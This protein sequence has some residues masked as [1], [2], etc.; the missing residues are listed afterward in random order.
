MRRTNVHS[1]GTLAA[2][3]GIIPRLD[4]ISS[5]STAFPS[6]KALA[7]RWLQEC[8]TSHRACNVDHDRKG[9]N[10]NRL[11]DVGRIRDEMIQLT[12]TTPTEPITYVTLSHRWGQVDVPLLTKHTEASFKSGIAICDLPKT[13]QHAVTVVRELGHRYLWIDSLCIRQDRDDLSDWLHEASLM[14]KVYGHGHFNISATGAIDG[15]EG[16]F[17]ERDHTARGFERV[18]LKVE[19]L[20]GGPIPCIAFYF[21]FWT[22]NVERAPLN[23]RGWVLQERIL[24]KRV[25]HF[26]KTQLFWECR[27]LQAAETFPSG[28]SYDGSRPVGIKCLEPDV[29]GPLNKTANESHR[30]PRFWAY[31]LWTGIA[32]TYSRCSLTKSGDKFLAIMGLAKHMN[33]LIKDMYVAG[34]WRKYLAS[35]L[36]WSVSRHGGT[37]PSTPDIY[38]A[39]T[40]SW[41]SRNA[42]IQCSKVKD[43]GIRLKVKDVQL[44]YAT[45]DPCGPLLGGRLA[46]GIFSR[47]GLSYTHS[48]RKKLLRDRNRVPEL[49][50]VSWDAKQKLHTICVI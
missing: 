3:T 35:E 21:P 9:F 18:S 17:R 40:W 6:T 8:C 16:L 13:F 38:T 5:S 43:K 46:N 27:E 50:C 24:S 41:L 47:V 4:D 49:P 37:T 15:S 28:T 19:G 12:D 30:D 48:S 45:D 7:S 34:M 1:N 25:L 26:G 20:N 22:D 11:L 14:H 44:D 31:D 39:P 29:A 2:G 36:A 33:G 10:P 23:L 32:T 42:E